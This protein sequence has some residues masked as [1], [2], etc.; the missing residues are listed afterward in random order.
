MKAA[1]AQRPSPIR[2]ERRQNGVAEKETA[3]AGIDPTLAVLFIER[4]EQRSALPRHGTG[5]K[6]TPADGP[7]NDPRQ[8][9]RL[10][11]RPS[12][13]LGSTKRSFMVPGSLDFA[14]ATT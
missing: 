4:A 1:I 12:G 10:T 13:K 14:A 2:H 8:E 6:S 11:A 7:Q 9:D 3:S 5:Q